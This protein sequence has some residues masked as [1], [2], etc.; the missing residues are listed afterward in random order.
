MESG[1]SAASRSDGP[2]L[3][4]QTAYNF[5]TDTQMPI[6]LVDRVEGEA[7]FVMDARI[8]NSERCEFDSDLSKLFAFQRRTVPT[9]RPMSTAEICKLAEV[10]LDGIG[11]LSLVNFSPKAMGD[12]LRAGP[13]RI[14]SYHVSVYYFYLNRYDCLPLP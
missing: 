10:V 5:V 6:V 3:L 13:S 11:C 4:E 14:G 8:A 2:V 1:E 12:T 7:E 9:E